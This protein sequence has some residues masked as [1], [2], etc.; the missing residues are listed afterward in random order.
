MSTCTEKQQTFCRFYAKVAATFYN[1][2]CT[3]EETNFT[4]PFL[5]MFLA[6]EE[7]DG[8]LAHGSCTTFH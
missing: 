7:C 6:L 3:L 5:P 2:T 1:I 8:S 4:V